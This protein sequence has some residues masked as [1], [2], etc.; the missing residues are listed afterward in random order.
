MTI[1][2]QAFFDR[3]TLQVAQDLIGCY[4]VH[5][6]NGQK[7]IGKIVETEAYLGLEDPASHA[8][9]GKN[10]RN[11]P[12]F[13]PVGHAYVYVSYGIHYCFNTVARHS[14]QAA[15]GVLIRALEPIQGVQIMQKN[16]NIT[17]PINITNGPGKLTQAMGITIEHKG[18]KL[19]CSQKLY[20]MRG[21][22]TNDFVI[23]KS[24]RIGISRAQ[25][26]P[27][28]FYEQGNKWISRT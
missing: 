21:Q 15:G 1:L 12:M 9:I 23:K 6:Y 25:E 3:D 8:Y 16:R 26:M 27:W 13:G 10:N 28:R 18:I 14:S 7:L 17:C 2:D 22:Q 19:D 5:E 4:L 20:I 11:A 24:K